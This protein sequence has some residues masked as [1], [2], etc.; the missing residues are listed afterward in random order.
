MYLC[1]CACV[2][3]CTWVCG[4]CVC[5]GSSC[6]H[7]TCLAGIQYRS[8]KL[9][10]VLLYTRAKFRMLLNKGNI[11]CEHNERIQFATT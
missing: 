8:K 10:G 2:S 6:V 9:K 3:V 4:V 5:A 1:V 7:T 11:S